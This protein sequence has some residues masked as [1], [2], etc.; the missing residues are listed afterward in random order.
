ML[1]VRGGITRCKAST[2]SDGS[3]RITP[4]TKHTPSKTALE[5]IIDEHVI[6]EKEKTLKIFSCVVFFVVDAVLSRMRGGAWWASVSTKSRAFCNGSESQNTGNER[7]ELTDNV[8][9]II[10]NLEIFEI[11]E[12]FELE[13]VN[14]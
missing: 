13:L 5:R 6:D 2:E 9:Q 12:I 11:F 7:S 3:L 8:K 14:Y 4:T 10:R 1:L